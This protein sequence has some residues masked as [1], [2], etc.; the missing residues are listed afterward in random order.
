MC[1]YAPACIASQQ[2]LNSCLGSSSPGLACLPDTA[3]ASLQCT[4][5][6][7][8]GGIS[9]CK[10]GTADYALM[11]TNDDNVVN[12]EDDCYSPFYPVS[13][14]MQMMGWQHLAVGTLLWSCLRVRSPV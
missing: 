1:W 3:A 5:Y 12:C 14:P 6:P 11:D 4:G 8:Q 7:Y 2:A 13:V 10:S 9:Q